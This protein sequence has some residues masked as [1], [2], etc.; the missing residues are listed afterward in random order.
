[1]NCG[2]PT[3]CITTNTAANAAQRLPVLGISPGGFRLASNVGDSNYNALQASV[4]QRFKHGL[5]FDASY[6]WSRALN[7]GSTYFAQNPRVEYGPSDTNRNQV[8]IINGLWDLPIGS[9][10]AVNVQNRILNDII[11]GWRL[12]NT[13]TWESGL[14]FTPTYAECGADQDIDSNFSSPGTSSD[15]RPNLGR[16]MLVTSVGSLNPVTH[17]RTYFQPVAPLTTNGAV[18][19]PFIRPAFG[20]IGN[21]GRN[22]FRGPSEFFSD[23]AIS[24]TFGIAESVKAQFQFQAFNVFN[25]VPLGVPSAT[26]ARCID[27]LGFTGNPGEITSVDSAV[28]G[29][30]LPY[31]RTLQFGARIEF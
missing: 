19:G 10:K 22:S 17:A 1:M 27:C 18:S 20:T 5:Q 16:G 15:C 28:S 12:S 29:T 31:M 11:G 6:S 25:V 21:I 4:Q 26:N 2:A 30:G 24:K 13:T 8:F 14:P 23:A 3:G 7:Y 9:G